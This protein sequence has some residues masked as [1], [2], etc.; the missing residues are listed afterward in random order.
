MGRSSFLLIVLAVLSGPAHALRVD[1]FVLL[2]EQGKAHELYYHK[3][4]PAIV[5]MIQGNGCPIVRNSIAD[6]KALRDRFAPAG[7]EFFMLNSNPQDD[8]DSIRQPSICHRTTCRI[9]S[10]WRI[11]TRPNTCLTRP[12]Q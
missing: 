4:A 2:D 3:N 8:R 11:C 6:F 10:V 9:I 1:N 5:I 12:F 7:V